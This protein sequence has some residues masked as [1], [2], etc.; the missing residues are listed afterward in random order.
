MKRK[1]YYIVVGAISLTGMALSVFF[2]PKSTDTPL[3]YLYDKQY[4]RAYE[5][6]REHYERGDRSTNVMIP[7]VNILMEYAQ[8]D[9]SIELMEEYVSLNPDSVD[10]LRFLAKVYHNANRS[11]DYLRVL[12]EIFGA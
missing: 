6:Y 10:A 11:Y 8:I 7:L 12:E 2:L 4:E 1:F 5:F 9:Q 3:M